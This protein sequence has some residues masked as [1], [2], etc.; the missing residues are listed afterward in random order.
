MLSLQSIWCEAICGRPAMVQALIPSQ[1]RRG[2]MLSYSRGPEDELWELTIAQVLDRPSNAGATAWPWFPVI[3]PNA[4]PGANCAMRRSRGARPGVT[5]NTA[6]DRGGS[7]VHE[8]RRMG[9]GAPGMC[10]CGSA[11][12][13]CESG[14]SH[15]RA[16]VHPA[17]VAHE[18]PVPLGAGQPSGVRADPRRSAVRKAAQ[19]GT[20]HLFSARPLGRVAARAQTKSALPFSPNDVANIQYTSGTTGQPKGVMLTHRNQVNNGRMLAQG[21]RFTERDRICVPCRCITASGV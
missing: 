2:V 18:G 4:T 20:C 3:N 5:R 15:A 10:S 7:V 17:E 13:Q 14:I 1:P 6:R 12:G 16:G 19:S 11:A 8:L 9:A 21:M